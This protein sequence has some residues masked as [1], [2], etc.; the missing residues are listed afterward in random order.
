MDKPIYIILSKGSLSRR[1]LTAEQM[2][3]VFNHHKLHYDI[4]PVIERDGKFE[5]SDFHIIK[6]R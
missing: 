4:I 5:N 6:R 2:Q 3:K 1:E